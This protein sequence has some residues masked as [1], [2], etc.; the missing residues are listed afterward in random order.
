MREQQR[1]RDAESASTPCLLLFPVSFLISR[2]Q[3]LSK[4]SSAPADPKSTLSCPHPNA[5]IS[6]PRTI[7]H[8]VLRHRFE[9]GEA[10]QRLRDEMSDLQ[11]GAAQRIG[12]CESELVRVATH[13][14]THLLRSSRYPPPTFLQMSAIR[15]CVSAFS[16]HFNCISRR[17]DAPAR[18]VCCSV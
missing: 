5:V 10:M 2:Y 11:K 4:T 13:N 7:P 18:G 6:F 9:K 3:A 16:H 8:T 12:E 14:H 1:A 17:S 15:H